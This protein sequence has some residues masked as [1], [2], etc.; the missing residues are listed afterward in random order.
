[1]FSMCLCVCMC[2]CINIFVYMCMCVHA[3]VSKCVRMKYNLHLEA[4]LQY[5]INSSYFDPKLL[6]FRCFGI[7]RFLTVGVIDL[8]GTFVTTGVPVAPITVPSSEDDLDC[9]L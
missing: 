3:R 2:I 1:M 9:F 5:K 4:T 6:A 7:Y 8:R